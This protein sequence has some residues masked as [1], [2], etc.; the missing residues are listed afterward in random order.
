MAT[1]TADSP[2]RLGGGF[3]LIELMVVVSIIGIITAVAIPS[4]RRY[5]AKAKAGEAKLQLASLWAVE[6]VSRA[7]HGVFATCIE[8]MGYN[9]ASV[10]YYA[11][12]FAA[13]NTALNAAVRAGGGSCP[14]GRHRL[15]PGSVPA[16]VGG[17]VTTADVSYATWAASAASFVAGAV[18]RVSPDPSVG[19]D[20]WSIDENKTLSHVALGY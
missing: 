20:A 15:V 5:Q 13:D 6:E 7:D 8:D 14:D 4:F 1:D 2:R 17:R 19:L 3:S 9:P 16:I 10:G 18:G 12:G 11:V